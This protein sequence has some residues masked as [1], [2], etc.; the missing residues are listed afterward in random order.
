MQPNETT[1]A[2]A[3]A[4]AFTP[5][6]NMS[7]PTPEPAPAPAPEPQQQQPAPAPQ[8]DPAPQ[9]EPAP[10]NQETP[11]QPTPQT[12]PA[13]Q[14]TPDPTPDPNKSQ[15]FDDYLASLTKDIEVPELPKATDVKGDDP[16]SLDKF[17]TE[18]GDKI[19]ERAL[20][21]VQQGEVVKQAEARAWNDVF[22]KYPEVKENQQLRDTIHN[23][24]LGAYARGQSLSPVEVADQLVGT[25]HGEYKRGVNDTNVQTKVQ[26]SQP[27]GGGTPAPAAP[28]INYEALQDGGINEATKQ[29]EALMAAGKI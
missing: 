2:P 18:F 21:K 5:G 22:T 13:P 29:I 16:E 12:P 7:Y 14:P 15:S 1:P 4:P 3:P 10:T 27:L 17:F 28:S 9:P 6:V 24:R 20:S 25:L 26:E 23:I 19:V 11:P 8:P